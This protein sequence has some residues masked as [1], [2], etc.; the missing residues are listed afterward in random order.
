ME[1]QTDRVVQYVRYETTVKV[2]NEINKFQRSNILRK[3]I[4]KMN[5]KLGG[6]N[7]ELV[8]PAELNILSNR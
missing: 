1:L 7:Y 2:L 5:E 8:M 4:Y 3:I 6:H